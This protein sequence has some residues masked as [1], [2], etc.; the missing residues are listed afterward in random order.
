[1]RTFLSAL[2][3]LAFL[4]SIA[5]APGL[6]GEKKGHMMGGSMMG[7]GMKHSCP[8][9]KHWVNGYLKK[10]GKKVKGYCR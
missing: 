7:P 4:G 2:A 3:M 5:A 6:A 9:G 8:K 10:D 1:M